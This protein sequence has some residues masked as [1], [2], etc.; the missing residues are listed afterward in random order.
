MD[1][2]TLVGDLSGVANFSN[3]FLSFNYVP[4]N[5]LLHSLIMSHF[6]DSFS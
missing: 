1:I 4:I 6:L 2:R 3:N 5:L